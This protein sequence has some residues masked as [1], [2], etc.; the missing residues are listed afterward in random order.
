MPDFSGR[1]PNVMSRKK[2]VCALPA[3]RRPSNA[4]GELS[5]SQLLDILRRLALTHQRAEP[6]PFYPLRYA[7]RELRAPVSAISRTYDALRK[8]GLLGTIRAS[9]TVL[10]GLDVAAR[11]TFKGLIGLP[12]SLSCF[13]TLQDYRSFYFALRRESQRRG[14]VSNLLFFSDDPQG[15]EELSDILEEFG[16][17][18]VVWFLP[19]MSADNTILRL[20]DKGIRVVGI[21]DGGVSPIFCNYEIRRDKA[22][23]AILRKWRTD[24]RI[25]HAT[26]V[27]TDPRS[28]A[29]EE[30]IAHAVEKAGLSSEYRDVDNE[31]GA[32]V[33][34][35]LGKDRR[36]GTILPGKSASV[37][38][39]R[40]PYAFGELLNR[41]RVA[42]LDGP[43]TTLYGTVPDGPV[44][45][46][47][48]NWPFVTKRI[49]HDLTTRRAFDETAPTIFEA[50][51]RFR[52]SL[53]EYAGDC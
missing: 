35:T 40:A 1:V 48:V 5:D 34:S 50:F 6:Q 29:D 23:I 31:A 49:V 46:L 11:I 14:F 8:E 15:R 33:I 19:R 18:F 3:P 7:A 13:L 32:E 16:V 43:T 26:I 30:M 10:E 39:L 41:C 47:T 53:R 36:Q 45:L 27:R 44:D 20:R 25:T 9:R 38:S 24:D 37:F 17:H 52:A 51:A 21:A 12:L 28:A 22:L 4:R 2:V 42:L